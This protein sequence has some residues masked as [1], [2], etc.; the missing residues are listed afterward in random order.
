MSLPPLHLLAAFAAYNRGVKVMA[1]GTQWRLVGAGY[2]GVALIGAG[3]VFMRYMQYNLH[4]DDANT[5]GAMWGFGD[6]LLGLFICGLFLIPTFV[7]LLLLAKSEAASTLYAKIVLGLSATLPL[8]VGL[9]F[10][11]AVAQGWVIGGPCMYRVLCSPVFLLGMGLSRLMVRYPRA[12][13]LTSYALLVEVG[14]L[15]LIV[16]SL[17]GPALWHRG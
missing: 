17:S 10:I 3:L 4:P 5:Y 13:Q 9:M 14:T 12:K 16:G 8:S 7:L 1:S 15:V 2:F 11:P 6:W